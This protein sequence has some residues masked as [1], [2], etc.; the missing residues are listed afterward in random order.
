[1]ICND[2]IFVLNVSCVDA[3]LKKDNIAFYRIDVER[4]GEGGGWRGGQ[5]STSM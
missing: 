5:L 2:N 4:G 3:F 1:M